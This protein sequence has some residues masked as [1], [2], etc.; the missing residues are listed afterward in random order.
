MLTDKERYFAEAVVGAIDH[1]EHPMLVYE[2]EK[3]VVKKALLQLLQNDDS[4]KRGR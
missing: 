2:E 4:E 3:A 1:V